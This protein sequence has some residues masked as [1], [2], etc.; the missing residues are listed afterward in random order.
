MKLFK[1]L[2]SGLL[3]LVFLNGSAQS[4]SLVGFWEITSVSMGPKSMTPIAKWINLK[5][6]HSYSSGNGWLQNSRGSWKLDQETNILT[7]ID[8]LGISEDFT[9][10]KVSFKGEKMLW[11]REENDIL[12]LVTL[13]PI[14]EKP[15]AP[16]DYLVGLWKLHQSDPNAEDNNRILIRW[17]RIYNEY[18]DHKK[19]A[20]GYWHINAHKP[21]ITFLPHQKGEIP[22]SWRVSVN[23][24]ELILTGIS[25]SNND[26]QLRYSRLHHF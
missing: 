7:A 14:T 4:S 9:G 25:D 26:L 1:K 10:F 17:D 12:V 22:E 19:K 6:D 16:A 11:E 3:L 5:K 2:L 21:E 24:T 18:V 15:M 20:S 8:S 23:K 13:K